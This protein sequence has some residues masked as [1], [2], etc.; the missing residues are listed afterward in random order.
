MQKGGAIPP[1]FFEKNIPLDVL[2]LHRI[3][4]TVNVRVASLFNYYYDI[5]ALFAN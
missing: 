2:F 3:A 1:P 5:P 4:A